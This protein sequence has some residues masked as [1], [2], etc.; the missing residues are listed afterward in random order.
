MPVNYATHEEWASA[1]G[2]HYESE[3]T[4]AAIVRHES[5]PTEIIIA[6]HESDALTVAPQVWNSESASPTLTQLR[7][8]GGTLVWTT[9]RRNGESHV[10]GCR[11]HKTVESSI[12]DS[13]TPTVSSRIDSY[14]PPRAMVSSTGRFPFG[15]AASVYQRNGNPSVVCLAVKPVMF[16]VDGS[17]I[18][19]KNIDIETPDK[20]TLISVAGLSGQKIIGACMKMVNGN[21]VFVRAEETADGSSSSSESSDH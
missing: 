20:P 3:P 21:V 7:L 8:P 11:I 14:T 1:T 18:E 9:R 16:A 2:Q 10:H 15:R 5:E 19:Q 6:R 12:A 4:E 13:N 17:Q